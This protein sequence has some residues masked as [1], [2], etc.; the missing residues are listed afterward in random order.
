MKSAEKER[1]LGDIVN[2]NAKPH[3]NII[4]RISKGYGIVANILGLIR[5]IPLGNRR[6]EI[7]LDLR[8][9]WFVNGCL[10]NS[11]IWQQLTK[12]DISDLSKIDHYLL[13]SILGAHPKAPVIQLYMETSSLRIADIIS[14]RRMIYLQTILKR[15]KTELTRRIYDAMKDDPRPD[16]WC[17]MVRKDFEQV[18]LSLDDQTISA[19]TELQYKKLVKE[20][21]RQYAFKELSD[22]Q[23]TYKK[24]KNIIFTQFSRPQEYLI[25]KEFDD[26]MKTVLYNLRCQSFQ[27]IK[28]NFHNKFQTHECDLCGI[29]RDSQSPLRVHF[30][31]TC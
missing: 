30:V 9:A 17:E 15:P 2:K 5:D 21:I 31:K 6:V 24:V 13:R 27:G 14:C 23:Q 3:T 19:M 8:Q 10:Y 20:K 4:E 12:R 29:E 1:Y 22:L 25:H 11:E 18:D 16:D 26:E 7:G 28:E